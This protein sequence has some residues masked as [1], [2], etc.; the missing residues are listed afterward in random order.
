MSSIIA[1]EEPSVLIVSKGK[2]GFR[3]FYERYPKP[4]Q[5][6]LVILLNSLSILTIGIIGYVIFLSHSGF[7]NAK[8]WGF[9]GCT[10]TVTIGL[11]MG[12]GWPFAFPIGS[13]VQNPRAS[14]AVAGL[15]TATWVFLVLSLVHVFTSLNIP[16]SSSLQS[17]ALVLTAAAFLI[18]C[19]GA[20]LLISAKQK[21]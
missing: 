13:N 17:G 8:G 12:I 20:A 21:P 1:M 16:N 14:F 19:A 11:I 7:S 4:N 3:T 18:L 2:L 9:A 10:A 6:K 15:C 5:L